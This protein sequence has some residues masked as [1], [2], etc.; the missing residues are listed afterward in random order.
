[1]ER[2]RPQVDGGRRPA[3]ASLGERVRVSADI[4]ADGHDELACEVRFAGPGSARWAAAPLTLA[5]ND[6]WEG[7][8]PVSAL[9]RARFQLR[10]R[11]DRF[12]TWRR[13]LKAWAAAGED[14][15]GELATGAALLQEAGA[16]A[17][18]RRRS[19]LE[20]VAALLLRAPRLLETEVPAEIGAAL[21]LPLP[22]SLL[23]L[24][25]S[26]QLERAV[27]AARDPEALSSDIYTVQVEPARARFSTWY[28]LFPRSAAAG[29]HGTFGD[30]TALLP[31][32]AGLGCDVLYLPPVH[33]IGRTNRKGPDGGLASGGTDPG[34]PWAIGDRTGGHTAVHPELGTVED[35]ERLAKEAAAAGIDIA[36]DLAFQVSPDHPW[37]TEHPSWFRRRADGS[38]RYAENPPKRYEDIYPLDFSTEDWAALWQEL[39]G[40]VQ[41]WI[42]RGVRVFRVDNPHTKPFAFWEWLIDSVQAEH[43]DVI[44]LAEAFT[45]PKVM[46][47][48]AKAGFSQSYTYFAWRNTKWELEEYLHELVNTEAADWFR[49]NFWPNTPDILTETLQTGGTPAFVM[50]LILAATLSASY[51]VYGPAFELQEHRP[52]HPG[53]EEY[54][55]SEKYEVRSWDLDRPDSLAGLLT[56]VNGVR[57]RYTALQHNR[58]LRFHRVDNDQLMAYSKTAPADAAPADGAAEDEADAGAPVLVVVNLDPAYPQSGWVEVD[59]A[60]LGLDPARPY[61]LHDQLT[62]ARYEWRGPRNF[63]RLDPAAVGAH[64]FTVSQPD[65]RPSP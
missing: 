35:F 45:R 25:N 64:L 43:P 30:V 13:D 16:A 37:V 10:A 50:R 41:C 20:A 24:L 5:G 62:H 46:A 49:P 34:S 47:R 8:F 6:S 21:G 42:S 27:A 63:V 17:R 7:S 22:A 48:L 29:R 38:I 11:I 44:F 65:T 23:E 32:V 36:L 26:R 14:V 2:I 18:G 15:A 58:T 52:R 53:S 33:P 60:A 56:R 59:L 9:G 19:A 31:Y 3:K 39:L 12:G 1:M 40:V 54:L 51:G 4:F 61:Q 55:H 28:E 57:R